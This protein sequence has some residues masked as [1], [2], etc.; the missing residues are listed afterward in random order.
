MSDD[1]HNSV[2]L[3]TFSSGNKKYRVIFH[4]GTIVWGNGK[5]PIDQE[6]LPLEN[7]ISVQH[8]YTRNRHPSDDAILD[9]N[10]FTINY[11][12]KD[13][14]NRWKPHSL[15]LGH[16]DPLQ[17]SSWVKTL[18]NHLQYFKRPKRLLLFVNPF[19][20]KRNALKIYEKYGKPLFQTAGVDVTVNVSQRKN[21]IRDFV[22]NHSLDMF[23]SIAC[24]GGDGTVS[25]LFN[26]LVL[27][28]CKNLGIDADDI[29]QDLPKPKIPI[30]IIPGGST[31]TIVY[32]LHGTI[33]PTTAVLNIIFGET[34]GLDLVSVYDESSLLR[35]YASVLSY[36]Y[37]GDV[38]YHSDK[39]RWMGPNRYNYSGF[40]KLMRNRGYEG[41]VAFFS[42]VGDLKSSKC[43]ENCERCLSRRNNCDKTEKQ[44]RTLKGKFFMISGA[45]ITCSCNRSP[46]GIAPYSHLGDGNVHLVL[47]RHTSILNNLKLLLRLSSNNQAVDDLPFVETYSAREFCFRAING[48]SRWN[49]D[50]EVQHQTNIR[51]KVRCQLL[52]IFSRGTPKPIQA[53]RRCCGCY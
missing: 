32:C 7:V 33:D 43:Y 15:T 19:G 11:A 52:T 45:N 41:E 24:V 42:E 35:L 21:Q 44:W 37:L 53:T 16:S 12:K 39:Y 17:V 14:E 34:L 3:S 27:R 40:K 47:V 5:P 6:S 4:K 1:L 51:A 18:Q 29:E 38:A 28:E 2:L 36:G 13:E 20:G 46:Q 23:D 8:N 49:C 9:P 26:G 48:P 22:L 50:G 30:G 31:D 25:E 10:H